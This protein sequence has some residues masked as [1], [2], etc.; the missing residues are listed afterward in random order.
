MDAIKSHTKFQVD[1]DSVTMENLSIFVSNN[2]F[3]PLQ[4]H[5]IWSV[6][7]IYI[8]LHAPPLPQP[9]LFGSRKYI[10]ADSNID[11]TIDLF[12]SPIFNAI[13]N[14]NI[15]I[16]YRIKNRTHRFKIDYFFMR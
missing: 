5:Y 4:V 1:N 15:F 9:R 8:V 3:K 13:E 12:E 10:I 16:S 11:K 14:E 2:I 6:L 7:S